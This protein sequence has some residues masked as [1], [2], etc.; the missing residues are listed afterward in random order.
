MNAHKRP[1]GLGGEAWCHWGEKVKNGCPAH[2]TALSDPLASIRGVHGEFK[3]FI[4]T[5]LT[6]H[7]RFV[8]G[9][10]ADIERSELDVVSFALIGDVDTFN[11]CG[12]RTP[13]YGL[14]AGM[15]S[16]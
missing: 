5:F 2:T 4:C 7:G 16:H 12:G 1:I 10:P 9:T 15:V 8:L 14:F 13:V 6:A 11:F 3:V